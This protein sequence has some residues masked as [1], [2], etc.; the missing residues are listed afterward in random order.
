MASEFGTLAYLYM[1]V[2]SFDATLAFYETIFGVSR[3]WAFDRFGAKVAAL[4]LGEGPLLLLADHLPPGHVRF[5]YLVNDIEVAEARL[6]SAGTRFEGE[7]IEMPVGQCRLYTDPGENPCGIF[8][9]TRP[10]LMMEA[11]ADQSNPARL[12][13]SNSDKA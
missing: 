8:V 1:G 12:L 13:R 10:N 11:Y 9:E 6:I 7:R 5:L 3:L 4:D 2:Q